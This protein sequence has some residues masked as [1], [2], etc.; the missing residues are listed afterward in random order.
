MKPDTKLPLLAQIRR[1][2]SREASISREMFIEAWHELQRVDVTPF[3]KPTIPVMAA[4]LLYDDRFIG[5]LNEAESAQLN[6]LVDLALE[7]YDQQTNPPNKLGRLL[8]GLIH[9]E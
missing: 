4:L 3:L 7:R 1:C 6:S 2:P 9:K 5:L 8:S